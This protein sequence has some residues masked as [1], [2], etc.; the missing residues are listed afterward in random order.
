MTISEAI[1]R[2]ENPELVKIIISDLL[3]L[4]GKSFFLNQDKELTLPQKKALEKSCQ[5]LKNDEPVQYIT[6]I[7]HFYGRTFKV[8]KNVLIP[9]PETELLVEMAIEYLKEKLKTSKVVNFIDV[10]TGS[11]CISICISKEL[12]DNSRSALNIFAVDISKSALIVAGENAKANQANVKFFC[13]DLL[14]SQHLPKR[15]D[16]I[17]ANLPYLESDY[18]QKLSVENSSI[19]AEPSV[20]LDGGKDGLVLVKKLISDLPNRLE[21]D[22]VAILEVGD[23]QELAIR[24]FSTSFNNLRIDYIKDF[25]GKFRFLKIS[26]TS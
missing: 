21:R 22:G 15:F 20:A 26:R 12:Q 5:R 1:K 23:N 18:K 14:S 11:G 9:R 16:F 24:K 2:A 13:S 4:D 25:A 3:N 7:S 17:A 19:N 8:N 6:G 10:G